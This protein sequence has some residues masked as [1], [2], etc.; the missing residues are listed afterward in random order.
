MP[1]SLENFAIVGIRD[2]TPEEKKLLETSSITVFTME[3]VDRLGVA[4]V[5]R[6]SI[7][8]ACGG[9]TGV[10]VSI[11]MDFVDRK[12]AP[13]VVTAEPGGLS[14]REAHLAMEMIAESRR[15]LSADVTE[16]DPGK[17][18]SGATA[19]LAVGLIASL[20]G[21]RLLTRE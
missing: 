18:P 17:D 7:D 9:V 21:R 14:F 20:L 16:I 1:L 3:D 13:G 19:Q 11:D 12:E 4:E 10:H 2:L 6:R 8:V 15:L 5:M